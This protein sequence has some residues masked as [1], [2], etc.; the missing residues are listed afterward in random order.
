MEKEIICTV[1]PTGCTIKVTGDEKSI[2]SIEGYTCPRGKT[3]A[4]SEVTNPVRTLTST[5]IVE[6]K[7][8]EKMLPVR[9]DKP[10]PRPALFEA[11]EI[12]RKIRVNAPVKTGDVLVE[13][14]IENGTKL[15]ACKDFK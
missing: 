2:T 6:T 5:V 12:V 15:I 11:M 4:E 13:N 1:C 7:D 14:F 9:T 10:I 8:G 3:Y